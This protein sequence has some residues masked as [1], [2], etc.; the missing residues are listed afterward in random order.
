MQVG[1]VEIEARCPRAPTLDLASQVG[2]V[3]HVAAEAGRADQGAVPAGQA[4]VSHLVPA[5][6]VEIAAEQFG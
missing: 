3:G 2:G 5:G 4:A 6:V 1:V